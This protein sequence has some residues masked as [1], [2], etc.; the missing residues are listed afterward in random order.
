MLNARITRR[1]NR[2]G[3]E[4]HLWHDMGTANEWEREATIKFVESL[5]KSLTVAHLDATDYKNIDIGFRI[6][7]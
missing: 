6:Y 2:E 7:G 3:V 4:L 5:K 1:R